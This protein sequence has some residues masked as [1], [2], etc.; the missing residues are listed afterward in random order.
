MTHT[1]TEPLQKA[2]TI[3]LDKRVYGSIAEIGGGQETA[4]WFFRAGGAA[5]TIAKSMSAYDMTFSDAIYG[6]APRY[7]CRERLHSM[8]DHEFQLILER[9]NS[10]R[11]QNTCFFVF[12]NTVATRSYTYKAD[13]HGWLGIRFQ[14]V[15]GEAPSQIDMHVN[16]H[17]QQGVQDQETLGIIGL[18]LIYAATKL[19]DDPDA[20]ITS[21]LDNV[22]P[23]L[24][25]IDMI[26][27]SG[28]AFARVDNRLMALRLVEKGLSSA[29]LFHPDGHLVSVAD[30]LW[31]KAVLVERSRFRPP[32]LFTMNLLDCARE[33]FLRDAQLQADDLLV[34]SEITLNNLSDGQDI[35]TTDYLHR[36][37]LLCALGMNVLISNYGEYYRLA[38]YLFRYTTQPIALA[39]GALSLR[40]LFDEK[41]YEHLPGGIL[42]SF[43]RLFKHDL[44]I[45]ISPAIDK[46]SILG[47]KDIQVARNLRHLFEHLR[48]NR[49]LRPLDS[50]NHD[51]LNIYSHEV[52]DK[53]KHHAVDWQ[54]MVPTQVAQLIEQRNLFH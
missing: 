47:L 44:S 19:H 17:G 23:Q 37:D 25:E 7:V 52:L 24:A 39:M 5:G 8:L 35:D 9:L 50:I 36:A 30:S 53:I 31:K 22:F 34:L 4:R 51:Y 2:L 20:I 42:E 10:A 3:N 26:D 1:T 32:T 33:A 54:Q 27:F 21:L 18:N 38:Q 12:A 43:G 6:H 28:P 16:L 46:G 14:T 15:P 49:N 11:G 13:G 41:Y 48:E 29:A 40:E 45:Y